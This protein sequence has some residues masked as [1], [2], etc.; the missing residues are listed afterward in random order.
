MSA[1]LVRQIQYSEWVR[2][3]MVSNLATLYTGQ[4]LHRTQIIG[5]LSNF[6]TGSQK[7]LFFQKDNKNNDFSDANFK[8]E[9]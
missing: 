9:T 6:A 4:R 1:C 8:N 2:I 5:Y 7:F 3:W